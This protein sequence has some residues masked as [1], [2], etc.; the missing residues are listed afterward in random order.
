MFEGWSIIAVA[1]GYVSALFALAWIG[2]RKTR[3]RKGDGGRPLI[4]SLSIAVYC[5]SW[6]FFGSVGLAAATGYDFMP[7]YLGP[8]IM[9]TLGWPI[10]LRVVRLA[11]SQN[12][13]SVADFLAARYGKSPAVAAIVTIVAVIG[14]LPYIALQLK[15]I[16]VS[17]ETLLG[18]SL[19][20]SIE[21]P[22]VAF[23]DTAFVITLTL[24]TFAVL[25][26]TRHIDATE[27]QDGLMMAIA[28]ESLVKLAA[29]IA[30]G[31][32][33]IFGMFG[34]VGDFVAQAT[35]S[36]VVES[37]FGQNSNGGKWLTVTFLSFV[38]IILL[39]RQFHVTVVENNS[40]VELRRA[41]WMFPAYLVLI[42]LFVIPIAVA[43]LLTLPAGTTDPDFYV[44]KLPLS[45]DATTMSLIAFVG[46]LSAATAMVI[47]ESIALAIMVSNGL[48][49]PLLLRHR[50]T[51]TVP[52]EDMGGLLLMIRRVA[53]FCILLLG[54]GVY[55]AL[56]ESQGL[57]AIGL[58][59]FAAIAQLA[60]AFFGGLVWRRGTARGAIAGIVVGF[61]VWSYTL[62]LPWAAKAGWVPLGL[63]EDGPFGLAILRPQALFYLSFEPLTHGVLWS[64][65]ANLA[66]FVAVSLMRLPE[67]VERLQ[68]QIFVQESS[69][70][71]SPAPSFRLWRTSIT[72]G[73]L[74]STAARYMGA[75]RAERS[76]AE[77]T[78]SLN[79]PHNS[80]AEADVQ[81]IRFTEHLLTSAIGA[82]SSR[83]VLS[84]LLRRGNV[85]SHSAL[86]LL[87]DAS[88]AL[89][90]NRDLLQSALDQVR[91]G[92]SV[93]DK[94]LR[95]ICW[96]RQF[97][98]LL[99]LPPEIGRVGVP[100]EHILQVCAARGDFG[101]GNIDTLVADRLRR[102]AVTKETFQERIIGGEKVL[103]IR[104]SSMPQGGIVT[105][106]SD[107]TDR[108]RAANELARA[109]ET[110]ERRVRE[111]TAEL[112]DVNGALA[113]AKA[114]A[115][116]ANLDKTRFVAAASHDILQP[117]NAAR[118]YAASL[119][120][121]PLDP[122]DAL[123][124]RNVDASLSAVEEIF[125]TLIEIS[126]IDAGRLEPETKDFPLS[127][128][129]DQLK[130]EF[131]PMAHE[132]GLALRVVA[133]NAWVHSD[134]RLLRR[135]LQNL[136]S[137]AIKYTRTGAVLLG[138][139]RNGAN[140][141]I[142]VCDTG[143]GIPDD[144]RLI[145]F[146]EFQRLEG[147]GSGVRGLGLGLSIVERLGRVLMH[148]IAL[149]SAARRGS[150]FSVTVPQGVVRSL[151][152]VEPLSSPLPGSLAGC[153][154]L[155]IDN[156]PAVLDGM[157]SLLSGWGCKVR[158]AESRQKALRLIDSDRAI[159]D[160]ILADYHLDSGTGV[161]VVLALRAGLGAD[162][163]AVIITADNTVEVQREVRRL[164]LG[165]LRKPLKAA[166]LRAV[167]SQAIVRRPAAAE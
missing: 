155:C 42:N 7:V 110:L 106:Y 78:S 50:L 19:L 70:R 80:A 76:F 28:A 3:S 77:Y 88:E 102:L 5:T 163:P 69:P 90:Y 151:T 53:I 21:V 47:V 103:E 132:R 83:L 109:N 71:S 136:V 145:I 111:R 67:P 161:D 133:T 54:Y 79:L 129:F 114:K 141:E 65:A 24:A 85:S 13:T 73:D 63:I 86:K 52:Q 113:I 142:L 60:P 162:V 66:A 64:V 98:E 51:D 41:A 158:T 144:K 165:L 121:R 107:I 143:P 123:L 2:D 27:H 95:L 96:N 159:P 116:Q 150:T 23:M 38:C 105:T 17:I 108:V 101:P 140:I 12:I 30:V 119:V 72:L 33:V 40:E 125:S 56:G 29:F 11:K 138:V 92:L 152:E 91:H 89:Q 137:N 84:L 43:G 112:L 82:A 6:T 18:A 75:E 9:F 166:S 115:D 74:Q 22:R 31:L 49:I 93:Y 149:K 122:T 15:A 135:I 55:Q 8:I 37:V 26:G 10:L 164:G 61:L 35:K 59:S 117:L 130:V 46:G 36:P 32:F 146:K 16:A 167:L 34:G 99:D 81:A 48:V 120:E 97:R 39:P 45:A 25:F 134:R 44:L 153:Y 100:L 147:P 128:I 157:S 124:A 4:Y 127:E 14:V 154:L 148:P 57:A 20:V 68:A 1:L 156:E 139:R 58:I 131:E 160:A 87:D 118:L 94:E 104:T 62:L 126:R